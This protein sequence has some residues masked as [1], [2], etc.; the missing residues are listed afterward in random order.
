[1][2]RIKFSSMQRMATVLCMASAAALSLAS[3]ARAGVLVDTLPGFS[4]TRTMNTTSL[5][6]SES[7]TGANQ[8]GDVALDL[9]VGGANGSMVVSLWS[10]LGGGVGGLGVQP[11]VDLGT[12]ATISMLAIKNAIGA[13]NTEG[14]INITNINNLAFATG[15]NPSATYWI[16]VAPSGAPISSLSTTTGPTDKVGVTSYYTNALQSPTS[17]LQTCVSSDGSCVTEITTASGVPW[18]AGF[19]GDGLTIA[20]TFDTPA[21]EPGGLAIFGSA[22]AGFGLLRRQGSR[23]SRIT[24]PV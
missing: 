1:V 4:G 21:P 14:L 11:S 18:T 12:I 19:T 10:D 13:T 20:G 7:F 22:L 17:W 16:K 15:L 8:L 2:S 5:S 6:S 24:C 23:A 3:V 9:K